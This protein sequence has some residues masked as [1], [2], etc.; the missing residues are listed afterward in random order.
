MFGE[1]G[2]VLTKV[3]WWFHKSFNLIKVHLRVFVERKEERKVTDEFL[4][5][6]QLR[7]RKISGSGHFLQF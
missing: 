5:V 2:L 6:F 1:T 7:L 4:F 3:Q